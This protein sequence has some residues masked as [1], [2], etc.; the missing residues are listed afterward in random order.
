MLRLKEAAET[1]VHPRWEAEAKKEV[2]W[3]LKQ[4]DLSLK[5]IQR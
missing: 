4:V 2:I 5:N 3:V 1:K